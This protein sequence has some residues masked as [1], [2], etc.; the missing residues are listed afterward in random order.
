MKRRILGVFLAMVFFVGAGGSGMEVHAQEVY[1]EGEDAS[2]I[3]DQNIEVKK[4]TPQEVVDFATVFSNEAPRNERFEINPQEAEILE[5]NDTVA[6]AA[7]AVSAGRVSDY[8]T[9]AGDAKLYQLDLQPGIFL[10][11]QLKQPNSEGLDYDLYILDAGG[12]ILSYSEYFTNINGTSGTLPEA[13]SYITA[14]SEASTYYLYVHSSQGGSVNEAFTLEYSI[15][16]ACDNFE[17]DDNANQALGFTFGIGGSYINSRNLSSPVDNDWYAITIPS[18]RTYDKLCLDI[19]TA[20]ANTCGVEVYKNIA[21]S[22]F[23]MAKQNL[24]GNQLSVS[25]GTYYVRIFNQKTIEEFDENDIQNYMFEITPVLRPDSIVITDLNG[26]EG[27]NKVVNYGSYGKH[28]RTKTGTVTVSGYVAVKDSIT[29]DLYGIPY[30]GVNATYYNPYWDANN[31]PANAYVTN[32]GITD[33][34]GLF[35]V[36]LE[37]PNAT[38][39]NMFDA[40]TSY[41]YFDDCLIKANISDY[42]NIYDSEVIFHLAYTV[43]H[44][45]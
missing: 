24:S 2:I 36:D 21:A 39:A 26:T 17:I 4:L 8:L 43:W 5:G 45:F 44:P 22:G 30:T 28:F 38:A 18:S 23:Q 33:S 42:Q 9:A 14:G 40:G 13:A 34:E 25:T 6:Y 3:F 31:T 12:E 35:S 27:L 1:S 37:L 20:S 41:H 32:T 16:N 11:A 10:Q 15:S 7:R 29:G 19:S